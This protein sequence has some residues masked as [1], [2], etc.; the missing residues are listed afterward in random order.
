MAFADPG[1]GR[2]EIGVPSWTALAPSVK[3]AAIPRAS[4]IAPAAITGTRDRIGDLRK[5]RKQAHRFGR[6]GAE[7]AAGVAA[8][9]EALGDDGIGAALS[10]H[11]ASSTRRGVAQDDRAGGLDAV[12][13]GGIGQ[14]EMEADDVG[15]K[16][17]RPWRT[18]PRRK[19]VG[20]A[21]PLPCA[22]PNS[23]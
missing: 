12:E 19:A 23:S 3:A 20:V 13:Q 16:R 1:F 14:A 22:T 21:P 2:V 10:S 11:S 5:Q 6:V 15:P 9:L 17:P 7:E 4:P 18:S 8:R